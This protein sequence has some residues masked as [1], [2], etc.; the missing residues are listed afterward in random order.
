MKDKIKIPNNHAKETLAGNFLNDL[1]EMD[2]VTLVNVT[3]KTING[4]FTQYDKADAN[5][6][7]RKSLLDP[8]IVSSELATYINKLEI[9]E[10]LVDT[11]FKF[12]MHPEI[13]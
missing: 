1:L 7:D 11:L 13:S 4:P 6:D 12:K 10:E 8:V 5:N 2:T 9:D 3:E